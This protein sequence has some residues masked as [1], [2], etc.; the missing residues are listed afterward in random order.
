MR[1]HDSAV[2]AEVERTFA[3]E[4]A[5]KPQRGLRPSSA[6]RDQRERHSD[7]FVNYS[8]P[9][10]APDEPFRPNPIRRQRRKRREWR[11]SN[12][13]LPSRART[14]DVVPPIDQKKKD[15]MP[16]KQPAP[17][18]KEAEDAQK[19]RQTNLEIDLIKSAWIQKDRDSPPSNTK[20]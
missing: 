13:N 8:H 3:T 14:H 12:R 20:K 9:T 7:H 18:T 16:P 4:K 1:E 5:A 17:P 15:S 19:Q 6:A 11:S 10:F 2:T